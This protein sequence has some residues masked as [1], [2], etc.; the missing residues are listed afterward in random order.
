MIRGHHVDKLL[1]VVIDSGIGRSKK[2]LNELALRNDIKLQ[3]IQATMIRN[4]LEFL[5]E[6]I[7]YSDDVAKIYL[8]RSLSYPEIGCAH[9]HNVA[10]SIIAKNK[11]G[12]V[13][14]ED[15]ARIC[16]LDQFVRLAVGFLGNRIGKPSLL[17][18][19]NLAPLE[20]VCPIG[21]SETTYFYRKLGPTPLAVGYALTSIAAERMKDSNSPISMVS[22]WPLEG[23]QCF[24]PNHQ[25]VHHGDGQMKSTIDPTQD[26]S[27]IKR[28]RKR[29][30]LVFFGVHYF[31]LNYRIISKKSYIE[32]VWWPLIAHRLRFIKGPKIHV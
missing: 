22:D 27:R 15:D 25:Y 13:I 5:A 9:S 30:I 11:I 26:S 21:K 4:G 19:S 7:S 2:L 10:R 20:T 24:S 8:G 28:T 18:F 31:L 6:K 14:L 12:G 3:I 16:N 29:S 17:N 1:V 32:K 23:I